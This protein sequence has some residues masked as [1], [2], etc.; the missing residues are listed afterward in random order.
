[1]GVERIVRIVR[2]QLRLCA[3]YEQRHQLD[4]DRTSVELLIRLTERFQW[5]C[6]IVISPNCA[7]KW[8]IGSRH[9]SG[10]RVENHTVVSINPTSRRL[11]TS[12]TWL[13]STRGS[14]VG[15]S[16]YNMG[17]EGSGEVKAFLLTR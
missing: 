15:K 9:V 2:N 6:L 16:Q 14:K 17:W 1:M 11:G 13:R 5:S 10:G 7:S 4:S 3:R 8:G 12:K